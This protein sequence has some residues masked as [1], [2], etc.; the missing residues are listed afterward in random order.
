MHDP[1]TFSICSQLERDH[2]PREFVDVCC[3]LVQP[4][5]DQAR[6]YVMCREPCQS[7]CKEV[8][9]PLIDAGSTR[10]IFLCIGH[11]FKRC[12]TMIKR[13]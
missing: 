4:A 7:Y 5:P 2:S 1:R 9:G 6:H 3:L 8:Y 12:F 10:G 11:I 13:M